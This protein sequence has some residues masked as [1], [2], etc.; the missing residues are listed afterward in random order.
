MHTPKFARYGWALALLAIGALWLRVEMIGPPAA[1]QADEKKAEK[2]ETTPTIGV[3]N[4]RKALERYKLQAEKYAALVKRSREYADERNEKI[5][6]IKRL[7]QRYE[8]IDSKSDEAVRLR[9]QLERMRIDM[10]DEYEKQKRE[11]DAEF[12]LAS[13]THYEDLLRSVDFVK[14]EK[15]LKLVLNHYDDNFDSKD[16]SDVY[17][18]TYRAVVRYDDSLDI[19]DDVIAHLNAEKL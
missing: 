16:S 7:S 4:V 8:E 19:T 5:A 6:E 9:R 10:T 14:K 17:F 11:L 2:R 15:G 18:R 1:V 12:A 3:I 13:T